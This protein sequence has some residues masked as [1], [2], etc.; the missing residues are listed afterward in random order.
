MTS[1]QSLAR[2]SHCHYTNQHQSKHI[3]E[4]CGEST[5]NAKENLEKHKGG[6]HVNYNKNGDAKFDD[7]TAFT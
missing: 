1:H 7:K 6:K 3:Q 5:Q 2:C 4:Q